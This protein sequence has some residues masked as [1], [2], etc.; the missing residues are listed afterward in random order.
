VAGLA[1]EPVD[2]DELVAVRERLI[3]AINESMT[4]NEKNFL[5]SIKRGEP[6][7][8]LIPVA[9]IE[10]LPAIRWKLANNS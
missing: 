8:S 2:Y 9:G 5:L 6:D 10:N 7:W 1:T 3:Q 4:D